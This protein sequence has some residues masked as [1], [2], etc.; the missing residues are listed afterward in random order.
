MQFNSLHDKDPDVIR[1]DYALCHLHVHHESPRYITNEVTFAE[2]FAFIVAH[3][4]DV[5]PNGKRSE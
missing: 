3:Y 4:Y 1:S 2:V 5:N